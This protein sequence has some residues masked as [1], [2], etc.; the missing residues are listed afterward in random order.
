MLSNVSSFSALPVQQQLVSAPSRLESMLN[1]T[2]A[3]HEGIHISCLGDNLLDHI[4]S[5]LDSYYRTICSAVCRAF[6]ASAKRVNKVQNHGK[7]MIVFQHV[8]WNVVKQQARQMW[9]TTP[10]SLPTA[11]EVFRF[12][13]MMRKS[14]K[15]MLGVFIYPLAPVHVGKHITLHHCHPMPPPENP[16]ASTVPHI[17]MTLDCTAEQLCEMSRTNTSRGWSDLYTPDWLRM[18][19]GPDDMIRMSLRVEDL[20]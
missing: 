11:S 17:P 6:R 1:S 9:A 10:W 2:F 14:E 16:S 3:I 4:M 18:W 7:V 19:L 12:S 5:F 8:A 13:T 20:P 15:G